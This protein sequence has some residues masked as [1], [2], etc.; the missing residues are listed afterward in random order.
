MDANDAV[1]IERWSSPAFLEEARDWVRHACRDQGIE[2]ADGSVQPHCR[3][4]SSAVRFETSEGPLGFKVNGPGTLHEATLVATLGD[5]VPDLVPAVLALDADRGWSWTRDAGPVMRSIA[6]PDQL[7]AR[8][9]G[10]LVRY[11]VAQIDLGNQVPALLETGVHEVSPTTLPDHALRLV[12]ELGDLDPDTGGLSVQSADALDERLSAYSDWCAELAASGI[13]NSIQ[14]DDLHSNNICWGGDVEDARIIDWGDAS[15]GHPLGTMLCT[16]NSIAHH[17]GCEIDEPRV[18][19][20]RDAYLEPF[21]TFAERS[22]LVR[23]VALARR[24]GCV[25]RALSYKAA[26][27]GEP[28]ATQAEL[29]EW[30][31]CESRDNR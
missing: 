31:G 24:T 9:E 26:L 25:A 22:D 30:A 4:W 23:Y 21:T 10:V 1:S 12:K 8:W 16:L 3:P 6:S 14:H 19:R 5:L 7:W 2:L 13:P 15:V 17:A 29:E 28:A 11:A 20:T 27:H 18:V